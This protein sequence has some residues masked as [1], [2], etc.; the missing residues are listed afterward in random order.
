L[1]ESEPDEPIKDAWLE[2]FGKMLSELPLDYAGFSKRATAMS[3]GFRAELAK[4]MEPRLNQYLR[5]LPSETYAEKQSLCSWVNG[6]LHDLGLA[7]RCPRTQRPAILVADVQGGPDSASRFRLDIRTESGQR[8]KTLSARQLP[9]LDL[10]E[11][12]VRPEP[13]AKRTR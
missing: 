11:D 5:T 2:E 3:H 10:M 13:I 1:Q 8:T 9:S 6:Q 12:E 4:A 7:I